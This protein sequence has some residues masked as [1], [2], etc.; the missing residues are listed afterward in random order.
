[1]TIQ[2]QLAQPQTVPVLPFLD[3]PA[4]FFDFGLLGN[5]AI[6]APTISSFG[7]F[8]QPFRTPREVVSIPVEGAELSELDWLEQHARELGRYPGEWLLIHRHRLLVH[9]R[10]FAELEAAVREH[11]IDSPFA[12]YVPTDEEANFIAI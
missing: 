5:R 12:Y 1:M 4:S 11:R 10:D 3:V 7:N 2:E 8:A 6:Q 9:S